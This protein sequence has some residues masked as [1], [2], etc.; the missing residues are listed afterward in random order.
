M[1]LL[2]KE[3]KAVAVMADVSEQWAT[4]IRDQCMSVDDFR[5]RLAR[6]RDRKGRT[7]GASEPVMLSFSVRL[8]SADQAEPFYQHLTDDEYGT[9]SFIFNAT[10]SDTKRLEGFDEAMA[11][12]GYIVDVQEHFH[13]AALSG[14]EEQIILRARMLVRSIIYLAENDNKTLCFIHE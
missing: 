1:Q 5:Y 11:V 10:F 6:K 12:E 14:G 7:Y 8:N 4:V 9:L 2:S 13:S 3:L